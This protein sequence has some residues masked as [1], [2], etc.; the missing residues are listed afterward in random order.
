MDPLLVYSI[1]MWSALLVT[2]CGKCLYEINKYKIIIIR[3]T[4]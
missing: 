1:V 2:L 3:D 4:V